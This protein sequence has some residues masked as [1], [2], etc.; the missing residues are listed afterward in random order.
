MDHMSFQAVC[1]ADGGIG[2]D[3]RMSQRIYVCAY[4]IPR[5]QCSCFVECY[6]N[7]AG[8]S[9]EGDAAFEQDPFFCAGADR[10]QIGG[11]SGDDQGARRSG[12]EER[13]SPVDRSFMP[14]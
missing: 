7:A 12:D 8:Q 14:K 11:G 3:L 5:S 9:I 6:A 1:D 13:E 2:I 10:A 4:E